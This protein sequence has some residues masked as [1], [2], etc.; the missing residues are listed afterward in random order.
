LN[1]TFQLLLWVTLLAICGG[2]LG[3]GNETNSLVTAEIHLAR[4]DELMRQKKYN[5]A[6]VQYSKA[7][8]LKPDFAEAYNNRGYATYSKYDGSDALEDLNR[9]LLLRT[10]FPHAYNTRGCIHMAGGRTDLA[11]ADFNRAIELQ[12]D[13]PRVFRNRASVLMKKGRFRAAFADFEAAG[14]NPWKVVGIL[15]AVVAGLSALVALF[16]RA[17]RRAKVSPR[18]SL[19]SPHP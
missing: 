13:Y 17:I 18:S 14:G 11:L 2:T 1:R 4:G 10:N 6:I 9:A 3:S 8:E 15:A 12:P 5:E 16:V 7:I 19:Q